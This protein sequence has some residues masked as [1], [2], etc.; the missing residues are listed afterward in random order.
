MTEVA[1]TTFVVRDCPAGGVM[2]VDWEGNGFSLGK[3]SL[4]N[5][6]KFP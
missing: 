2:S 1:T 6:L 3:R 5:A 4:K